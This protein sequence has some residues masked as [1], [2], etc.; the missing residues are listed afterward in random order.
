MS[1]FPAF[2]ELSDKKILVVGAGKIATKKVQK[3]LD[4]SQNITIISPDISDELSLHVEKYN[5][6]YIQRTYEN[7]D[8][9]SFDIVIV[10]TDSIKLQKEIYLESREYRCLVSCVDTTSY[11]DFSF[12]SYLSRGELTIAVTTNAIS[13]SLSLHVKREIEKIIPDDVA[14]FLE[15]MKELRAT[16]P[17]GEER[18]KLFKMKSKEYINRW[19]KI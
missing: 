1:H 12:G 13:P 7:R 3:L 17:K 2:I 4:F 15:K 11:S 8:I 9:K 10:A 16:L 18:M 5:L 14:Q 6:S 19:S